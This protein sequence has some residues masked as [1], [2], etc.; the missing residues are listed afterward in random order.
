MNRTGRIALYVAVSG[1]SLWAVGP[2]SA[3]RDREVPENRAAVTAALVAARAGGDEIDQ[4]RTAH[5]VIL[6]DGD[7]SLAVERGQLLES[8]YRSYFHFLKQ[9]KIAHQPPAEKLIVL[10]FEDQ[11]G[12]D[13]YRRRAGF[14]F[15]DG[16]AIYL[17]GYYDA[18]TNRAAFY[19]QRRGGAYEQ[20]KQALENLAQMLQRIPGPENTRITIQDADGARQ[21]TKGQAARD[22]VRMRDELI[23]TFDL[24]NRVVTQH[25]GAHQLAFNTGLQRRDRPYPFWVSEGLA[26]TFETPGTNTGFGAFRVNADRLREYRAARERGE[27]LGLPGLLTVRAMA[28][29]RVLSLYAESWALFFFLARQQPQALSAYLQELAGRSARPVGEVVD[30]VEVFRRHFGEDLVALEKR[31]EVFIRGLS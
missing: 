31:W 16:G 9:M 24:E 5:Y 25:E 26:C 22:L 11:A 23:R 27:T 4:F 13:D 30:E 28:P 21:S 2:A 3:Q 8:L 12:F 7:R 15:G 1:L 29:E 10:V 20:Q 6:F 18:G 19:N 14:D 17:Q